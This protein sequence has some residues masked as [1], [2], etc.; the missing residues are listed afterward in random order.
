MEVRPIGVLRMVDQGEGDEKI[1]AVV[2]NDPL[3]RNIHDIDQV[4]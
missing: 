4:L 3:Y 1:L 2:D